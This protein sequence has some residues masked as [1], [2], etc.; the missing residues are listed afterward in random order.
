ML[1]NEW[2]FKER[3]QS[4]Y[5]DI[6]QNYISDANFTSRISLNINMRTNTRKKLYKCDTCRAQIASH[7]ALMLHIRTHT[8]E[9]PFSCVTCGST[10]AQSG[11]LKR[12]MYTHTGV[13]LVDHSLLKEEL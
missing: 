12:H 10:F 8:G 6:V 9:K 4:Q 11:V 5:D 3:G 13:T 7:R 2:S 1:Y